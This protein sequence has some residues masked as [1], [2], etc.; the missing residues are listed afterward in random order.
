MAN[1]SKIKKDEEYRA[2]IRAAYLPNETQAVKELIS[3]LNLNSDMLNGI[4]KDA[5]SIVKKLRE[6]KSPGLMETF[7]AEYGL[8]TQ[9]GV[10][11]MCLA[12]ALLRV[13][14]DSTI[15]ALINDKIASANWSRHLGHSTSPLVNTSTWALMLTGKV[16]DSRE[17][18]KWNISGN[19][20]HLIKRIGEPVIRTAVAQSMKILGH[21]FVL[22]RDI[23]EAMT[24]ARGMELKGYTYS[25]D[26]LG[27]GA[28]TA[29][30]AQHYFMSYTRAISALSELCE[31]ADIAKNPGISVKL[32]ALHP[33]YEFTRHTQILKELVPRVAS[34]VHLA[35]NA[36]MGFN[37]DAEEADRLDLSLDIIEEVLSNPDL[38]GWHGFGVVVQAYSPRAPFVL[39]WLYQL[40][41]RL[42]RKIMVRL[43]KGAYWDTEIK[44]AQVEGL[45]AY[46]V[47]TRKASTDICY[48]ACAQ[49][50]LS[51]TDRIYP[52]FATH[53]AYTATAILNMAGKRNDFEFQRLHGMGESLYE[54]IRAQ[55]SCRCRIYAPVGIHEDLLA[56]L[57]RRLLENGANSSF[58][59]QVLDESVP[60]QD[61]VRD[62][63]NIIQSSQ[64][65]SNPQI[66]LP[67]YILSD[68]RLNSTGFN[69]ANPS[70]LQQLTS[71]RNIFQQHKWQATLVDNE[72]GDNA[73]TRPVYNPADHSEHV[74][75]VLEATTQ[76]VDNALKRAKIAALNWREHPAD[77]RAK[78]LERLADLYES[79]H[80]ELIALACREAGKSI[81][82]AI[83]EVREAVDFCRYYAIRA[84]KEFNSN[85]LQARGVF[86]CISP[87]NF[88][89]AIFSGQIVAALVAGNSV[90]AKPAEQ[91]PLIAARAVELMHEAGIPED[92][93]QLL[94]GDGPTIGGRL[95]SSSL[96]DGICFTGSTD[97]ARAINLNMAKHAD[98][99][100][101]LIAETGGLN[102][103]IVDSTALP[104][105]VVSDIVSS[106]FQSA[107]QRCSA[108]RVLY[109]QVDI[110]E[111]IINML[112]GAMDEL[113]VGN[114]WNIE[115]DVGPVID[116]EA[117]R[118]IED[119]CQLLEK[120]GRL[121]K[122]IELDEMLNK[123]TYVAPAAYKIDSIEQLKSEIFG[124]ILHIATFH[125]KDL[126]QVV[127]TINASRYGLTMGFHT[128]VDQRVQQVCEQA[129][130]GNLYINR[131]QIG[132]VVGVQPFG[133]EGLSGT[134]PKAGGPHYL[135]RFCQ[136][137]TPA[138]S[139][140][141]K[142]LE[143]NTSDTRLMDELKQTVVIANASQPQW[144]SQHNRRDILFSMAESSNSHIQASIKEALE[145]NSDYTNLPVNL[146]GP[147]G[148]DNQLFLHGRG[149]IFCAGEFALQFSTL[150]LLTGNSVIIFDDNEETLSFSTKASECGIQKGLITVLP[151]SLN[152]DFI[153]TIEN[154]AAVATTSTHDELKSI[155]LAM[156]QRPGPILPLLTDPQD[157]RGFCIERS[158]CIDT[159]ASGGNAS[160][161]ASAEEE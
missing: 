149:V 143:T 84:R 126:D 8:S 62:P 14:D 153:K 129:Q 33:R 114:P 160:L 158:L 128:R 125:S 44:R 2:A 90:I 81:P 68:G 45:E 116:E 23:Q 87:W 103:M 82:D 139:V 38:T 92:V 136:S 58:V 110:A 3:N 145:A 154:I 148:E 9:E 24:R 74:G 35:K 96:I 85:I 104:E 31:H 80:I 59:N 138:K 28:H 157:W 77:D 69:I 86:I 21:Q 93:I 16:I 52:Q 119:H 100:A 46:P 61:V 67:L 131:N 73:K 134:G 133:G 5:V 26:M 140:N 4:S 123:G 151:N 29:E 10:S 108:L 1:N 99:D 22:G 91:T 39:D 53:N 132:A 25:Y 32:S 54:V 146:S 40:A 109:L 41:K 118:T 152:I 13:P 155:R 42:D 37:I 83:G 51:M 150:A 130:V 161:L 18:S 98:P 135:H 142:Q 147:T 15:D 65:I 76:Q 63:I 107:G 141:Y 48:L 6:S 117:R 122:K 71:A 121:I 113:V 78:C 97:T 43:V 50:L 120:Q 144:N 101:P 17:I 30:D 55:S 88:P 112:K 95:T 60:P 57:V 111:K 72:T 115:T 79:H 89:L 75:D 11:L 94:P 137:T 159:T 7:L 106:A 12:E 127:A 105:Q 102:A 66:P 70:V 49:K 19:I 56:Y 20:R 34:L 36:N 64:N 124:P 156:A 47:F 27:E